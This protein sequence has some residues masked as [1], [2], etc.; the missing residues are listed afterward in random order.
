MWYFCA[1]SSDL[2]ATG[3]PWNPPWLMNL[4]QCGKP[5]ATHHP[6]LDGLYKSFMVMTDGDD[7][8]DSGD[9]LWFLWH[10]VCHIRLLN[11][12]RKAGRGIPDFRAPCPPSASSGLR[13]NAHRLVVG[14]NRL[15]NIHSIRRWIFHYILGGL[16]AHIGHI[17][18]IFRVIL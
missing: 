9:V 16:K 10:W 2:M 1:L 5:N 15:E 11:T 13:K 17:E 7:W 8:I 18:W 12:K 3:C 6:Y 4:S 14:S